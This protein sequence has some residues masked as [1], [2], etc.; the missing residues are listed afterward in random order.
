MNFAKINTSHLVSISA[1]ERNPNMECQ[2]LKHVGK[3]W[4]D[5]SNRSNYYQCFLLESCSLI[6]NVSLYITKSYIA[7]GYKSF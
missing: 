3:K 2:E 4:P 5:K 1:D 6:N 7:L